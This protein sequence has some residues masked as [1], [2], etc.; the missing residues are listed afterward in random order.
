MA[1]EEILMTVAEIA[2]AIIGFAGI[3]AALRSETSESAGSLHRLR[4]R[5]MVEGSASVMLFAF[6]PFLLSGLFTGSTV[7]AVGS[8][9]I[10]ISS[11]VHVYSVFVR[12]RRI[13]DGKTLEETLLF[14]SFLAFV[15]AI[16]EAILI[17]N[18]FGLLFEPSFEAYL[19]GVLLPLAVA[20]AMFVRAIFSATD[21]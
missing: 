6:L 21:E 16:V 3:V 19:L 4:L 8:G 5:L 15:A 9:V 10:A 20:V 14:D 13:F 11:P 7:W 1:P 2:I 17:F 18:T 12:Q